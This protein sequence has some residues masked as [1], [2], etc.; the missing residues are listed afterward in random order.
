MAAA[1]ADRGE[2]AGMDAEERSA[3]GGG[4]G[5]AACAPDNVGGTGMAG[6]LEGGGRGDSEGRS[7][8]CSPEA[9]VT[10]A[11]PAIGA[12]VVDDEVAERADGISAS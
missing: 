1:A 10:D 2:A 3:V 6:D 4:A 8:L 9:M 11:G 7:P 12:S 5:S